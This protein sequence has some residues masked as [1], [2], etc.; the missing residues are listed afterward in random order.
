MI[1]RTLRHYGI[2]GELG[3]G[4]MGVV[5]RALDTRLKRETA[6]KV[7]PAELVTDP[8]RRRRFLLEAQSAA[9]L[10]RGLAVDARTDIFSFGLLLYELLTGQRPFDR[11]SLPPARPRCRLR[12]S[13]VACRN[14]TGS[15]ARAGGRSRASRPTS[16]PTI[17]PSHSHAS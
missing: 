3:S 13:T 5:Y 9:S 1:G 17:P 2:V 15:P 11:G 16:R 8:D 4:G 12:P 10:A 6:L 14:R 7:L